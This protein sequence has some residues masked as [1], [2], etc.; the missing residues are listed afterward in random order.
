MV[1]VNLST[2]LKLTGDVRLLATYRPTEGTLAPL[3]RLATQGRLPGIPTDSALE[4][5]RQMEWMNLPDSSSVTNAMR[6]VWSMDLAK[7]Y[8]HLP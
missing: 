6:A 4:V 1:N 8:P 3:A 7:K 5:I 2:M